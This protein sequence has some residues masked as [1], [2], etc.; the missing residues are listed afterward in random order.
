MAK[1]HIDIA[2]GIFEVEGEPEF[3]QD[4]FSQFKG[5][6][7]QI[8]VQKQIEP[9]SP[10]ITSQEQAQ[11]TVSPIN[12]STDTIANLLKV[13]SGPELALAAGAHLSIVMGKN[14]FS[15]KDLSTEMRTAPGHFKQS[16]IA[17]LS[18]TLDRLKKD[19]KIR[20]VSGTDVFA[21]SNTE[22]VR[23]EKILDEYR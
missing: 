2:R 11:D 19:D 3:I 10:Q 15:R 4:L 23:I 22:K 5:Q 20:L 14:T 9:L 18:P 21:L 16:Y 7:S 8:S 17:N 12:M 13:S 1:L 6:L